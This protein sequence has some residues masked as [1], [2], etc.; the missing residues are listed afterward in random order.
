MDNTPSTTEEVETVTTPVNMNISGMN[1]SLDPMFTRPSS[2]RKK[3]TDLDTQPMRGPREVNTTSDTL[4]H[5]MDDNYGD[6][7][8]SS[9]LKPK[10]LHVPTIDENTTV[11]TS[12]WNNSNGLVMFPMG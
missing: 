5:F 12:T 10:Q 9:L 1:G 6:V 11:T 2:R 3:D 7:L 8:R 4:D